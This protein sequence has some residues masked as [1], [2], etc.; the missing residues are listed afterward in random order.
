MLHYIH[1]EAMQKSRLLHVESMTDSVWYVFT[2][3][4][5][6]TVY[7]IYEKGDDALYEISA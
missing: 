5:F 3:Y 1:E 4:L 7:V 2:K 6:Q